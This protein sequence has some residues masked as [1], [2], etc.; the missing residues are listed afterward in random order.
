M[1][2]I[3][4]IVKGHLDDHWSEWFE[5]LTIT[6][7][8]SNETVLSGHVADQSALYGLLARLRDLGLQLLAVKCEEMEDWDTGAA[9]RDARSGL[10]RSRGQTD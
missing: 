9:D 10:D 2:Q 1:P 5:G 8:E 7:A 4:I 3:E 6:T